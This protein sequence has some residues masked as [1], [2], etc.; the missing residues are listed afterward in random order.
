MPDHRGRQQRGLVNR[1]VYDI[2]TVQ[3]LQGG[4]DISNSLSA[5]SGFIGF[6]NE[7]FYILQKYCAGMSQLDA[8]LRS[9]EQLEAKLLFKT[10]NLLAQRRLGDMHLFRGSTKFSVSATAIK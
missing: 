5:R 1:F 7:L 9:R 8:L 10:A 6:R 2:V 3:V 4:R